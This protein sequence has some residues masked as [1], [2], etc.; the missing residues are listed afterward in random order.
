V[1]GEK[2]RL[3]PQRR[4]ERKDFAKKPFKKRLSLRSFAS[5]R[6]CGEKF[7]VHSL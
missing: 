7:V 5:L 4:E 6:L 1:A 2:T 3:S